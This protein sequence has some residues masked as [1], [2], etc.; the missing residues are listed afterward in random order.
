MALND[1]TMFGKE[2]EGLMRLNVGAPR[3]ALE[4]ILG[5]I[6]SAISVLDA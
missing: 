1:G 2:G 6:A 3:A 5:R 4:E